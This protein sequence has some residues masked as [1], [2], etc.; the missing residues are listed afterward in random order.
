M[1]RG[2]L[3]G[4]F[5]TTTLLGCV[6]QPNLGST[7]GISFEQFKAKT[8]REP[9]TGLY[10]LDWDTPVSG[11]AALYAIW[12]ATQ[13]GALAVYAINGTDIK[14]D[15]T[16]RKNLTYCVSN[17]FGTNKQLVI[18]AMKTASDLGWEKFADVNFVY[19]PAQD[20]NC[21]AAN[22]AVLFDVNPTNANGQ[23]LMR[24]FFPNSPRNERNV[25]I[26]NTAFQAGGTG[27]VPFANI[28][29]HELGHTI[30]FR[31]E[32]IRPEANATDCVE[33]NN[34]RALTTYDSASVMHYPQCN[35]TSTNLA[36]TQRDQQGVVALYGPPAQNMSPTAQLTSPQNGATVPPSF[37]VEAQI[38][39]TDLAKAELNIDGALAST[40]MASPFQF[41]V[42]DL[43]VGAHTL[44][45]V[46]T[47]GIGQIT[48]QSISVTVAAS[49]GGG[50]GSGSGS[51]N[52]S[53]S[54]SGIND[55]DVYG[56]CSTGSGAGL[57]FVLLG[58]LGL[59]LTSRR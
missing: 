38:V 2:L 19:V 58:L 26:D 6:D 36:F 40:L 30:G 52:G 31:H 15:A 48:R 25:L 43:A 39:D 53:G 54:G 21:T 28:V 49:G 51:G 11:D 7:A 23:Y 12:E 4:T 16:Q 57:G 32:H 14:W 29:A 35:G 18:D 10:V 45:I 3:A 1:I 37:T 5:A 33:D 55:G 34:F 50:N 42:V 22:T 59:A 8:Y 20:A 41:Q 24:S 47:D 46:A 13:Q 56:G 17:T 27:G 44:E 9:T